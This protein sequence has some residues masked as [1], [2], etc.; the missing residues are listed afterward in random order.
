[1]NQIDESMLI[2][3]REEDDDEEEAHMEMDAAQARQV[4]A[5]EAQAR[6]QMQAQNLAKLS[7]RPEEVLRD[8]E[9]EAEVLKNLHHKISQQL[10]ML[11]VEEIVLKKQAELSNFA[12]Y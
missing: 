10:H 1:M 7:R 12:T 3:P 5:Q 2:L 11:Q 6:A 4:E 9:Q 8:L